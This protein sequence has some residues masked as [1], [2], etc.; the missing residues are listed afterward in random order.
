MKYVSGDRIYFLLVVAIAFAGLAI[1]TSASLGLL[2]RESNSVPRDIFL[3]TGLG[4]GLGFIALVV[5][6]AISLS[7]LKRATPYVYICTVICTSLVFMP[8]I[9]FRSGGATRWINIGFTTIQPSEFLKIGV[10]LMLAWW[11]SSHVRE[12]KNPRRGLVPFMSILAVPLAILLAQP[13]TSTM[14][15]LL[16]TGATMYFVA[17]A[18]V[19]DFGVL[20]LCTILALGAILLLRPYALERVKTF[21]DPSQDSLKSSYQIQQSLI[22]IGSG[23]IVGRGFGQGV[24]KFNYLP[25]PSGDSVFAVFAEETGFV[26]AVILLACLLALVARGIVIA[27]DSRDL[28]GGLMAVGFSALI[29]VQVFINVSAMLGIIPLTGLPLPFVSH[30]GTALVATLM[31]CGFILNVAAHRKM[32][33]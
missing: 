23:G 1:Y 25:E 10:V 11:L 28:F 32:P 29:M 6:R 24:E 31:M 12:L 18:P 7:W 17:G 15:L 20:A 33:S 21:M 16:L 27:G 13:N 19:R 22:A 9:G 4:F 8:G 2:A 30:G 14:M 26:G 3:Q 5:A